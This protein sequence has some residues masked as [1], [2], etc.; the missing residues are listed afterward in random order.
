MLPFFMR[1]SATPTPKLGAHKC[2]ARTLFKVLG[3]QHPLISYGLG[4][5]RK[6]ATTPRP[7]Q[8]PLH[9]QTADHRPW[10][11]FLPLEQRRLRVRGQG[12]RV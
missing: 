8:P 10:K 7:S 9:G 4:P 1:T 5:W 2:Y 6:L 12:C 11:H 3:F